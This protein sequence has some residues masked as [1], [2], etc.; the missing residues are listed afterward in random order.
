MPKA[1]FII[2]RVQNHATTNYRICSGKTISSKVTMKSQ[3]NKRFNHSIIPS[4]LQHTNIYIYIYIYMRI[5]LLYH[6]QG[7][8]RW[9]PRGPRPRGPRPSRSKIFIFILLLYILFS[10]L[11]SFQNFNPLLLNQSS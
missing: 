1:I 11:G 3:L 8:T 2:I 7:R 6:F 10:E 9:G 4:R 5:I